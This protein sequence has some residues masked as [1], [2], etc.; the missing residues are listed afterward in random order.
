MNK[1]EILDNF[2]LNWQVEKRSLYFPIL[3]GE[4]RDFQL[5]DNFGV[6]RTDTN[7]CLGVCK[8]GYTPVQNSD[9]VDTLL[10]GING[11]DFTINKGGA[12]KEGKKIFFLISTGD[13]QIGNGNVNKLIWCYNSHDGSS[14]LTF[15]IANRVISCKNFFQRSITSV[16]ADLKQH[17]KFQTTLRHTPSITEKHDKLRMYFNT[18][19]ELE[20]VFYNGLE[21]LAY[22]PK[23]VTKNLIQDIMKYV[24]KSDITVT[25]DTSTR[26]ENILKEMRTSID[27]ELA[28]KGANLW[29][30]FNGVTYY[31]NHF[32]SHP[33]RENGLLES[34]L[35]GSGNSMNNTAYEFC[36]A[37]LN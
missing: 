29:G 21:K 5:T 31:T 19:V 10:I 37:Q 26:Q 34:V 13:I 20:G 32:K 14:G 11:H 27:R 35:I 22:S 9:I 8:E 15:G 33:Q 6:I 2:N 24:L 18:L 3:N 4:S 1:Q 12:F 28:E 7:N 36:M 25:K 23:P 16:N 17:P 30:L